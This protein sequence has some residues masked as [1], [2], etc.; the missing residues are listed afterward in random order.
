[1]A[2]GLPEAEALKAITIFPARILGVAD[3]VGSLEVGKDATLIVSDGNPLET[4]SQIE[5]AYVQGRLVDLSDRH[6][7]LWK[8]YQERLRRLS[9]SNGQ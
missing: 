7:S 6:K 9:E 1:M 3:H 5:R 4:R 8:K 2:F